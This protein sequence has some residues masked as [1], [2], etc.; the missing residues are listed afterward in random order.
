MCFPIVPRRACDRTASLGQ[1]RETARDRTKVARLSAHCNTAAVR[2]TAHKHTNLPAKTL[3]KQKGTHTHTHPTVRA[4]AQGNTTAVR[5]IAP[6]ATK[7]GP[8]ATERVSAPCCS[9]DLIGGAG[10]GPGH[11]LAPPGGQR[12]GRSQRPG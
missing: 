3:H 12:L 6:A 1:V 11:E 5:G 10:L 7:H 8:I 2:E 4:T 9:M